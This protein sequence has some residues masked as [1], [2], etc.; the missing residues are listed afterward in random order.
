LKEVEKAEQLF[1]DGKV[2]DYVKKAKI[3][4]RKGS[5]L[6]HLGNLDEAI[7]LFEQ[8]LI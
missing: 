8:S 7:K 6:V 3:L 1:A 4:G 2:K 5:I